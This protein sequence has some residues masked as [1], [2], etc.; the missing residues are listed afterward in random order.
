MTLESKQ[1]SAAEEDE[2]TD[3]GVFHTIFVRNGATVSKSY[4]QFLTN[5]LQQA[6]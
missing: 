3:E 5:F 4:E 6:Q 2:K 1:E